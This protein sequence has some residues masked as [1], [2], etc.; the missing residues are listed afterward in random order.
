MKNGRLRLF[1]FKRFD[2]GLTINEVEEFANMSQEELS[3]KVRS[4]ALSSEE[5]LLISYD[6]GISIKKYYDEWINLNSKHNERSKIEEDIY[7]LLGQGYTQKQIMIERGYPRKTVRAFTKVW[8]SKGNIEPKEEE[9]KSEDVNNNVQQTKKKK[10]LSKKQL[11][12]LKQKEE[13]EALELKKKQEEEEEA[14]IKEKMERLRKEEEERKR[15]KEE[16]RKLECKDKENTDNIVKTKNG[17]PSGR[18]A[19]IKDYTDVAVTDEEI[20]IPRFKLKMPETKVITVPELKG[21]EIE[22]EDIVEYAKN[23]QHKD[24]DKYKRGDVVFVSNEAY[25]EKNGIIGKSRPALI[26]QNNEGNYHSSNVIVCY[27][28][29]VLKKHNL[30]THV[31]V[32][33]T[34]C[35]RESMVLTEQIQTINKSYI[36]YMGRINEKEM[37]SVEYAIVHSLG[38]E[39]FV[40]K[41]VEDECRRRGKVQMDMVAYEMLKA[42]GLAEEVKDYTRLR[43]PLRTLDVTELKSEKFVYDLNNGINVKSRGSYENDISHEI[44]LEEINSL[45]DELQ[46]IRDYLMIK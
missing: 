14:R 5:A 20:E 21:I 4:G 11:E 13:K 27:I 41:I 24:I 10:K 6:K 39:E 26:I 35:L 36:S 37:I 16:E 28:T 22:L 18:K 32:E 40:E 29:S 38:L 31:Y 34:E 2:N 33:D 15:L 30:P 12:L 8:V 42:N 19:L 23:A 46:Q 3:L 9:V 44:N 17:I 43:N 1:Y 7:S 25:D 45:I